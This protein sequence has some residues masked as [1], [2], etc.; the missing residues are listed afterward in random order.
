MPNIYRVDDIALR[1]APMIEQMAEMYAGDE[2]VHA[3]LRSLVVTREEWDDES[4]RG[5]HFWFDVSGP[6]VAEDDF[7]VDAHAFDV[8]G[9]T[10]ESRRGSISRVAEIS[11]RVMMVPPCERRSTELR[12]RGW[13]CRPRFLLGGTKPI[14]W[15]SRL[16]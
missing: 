6:P 12:N 5:G 14:P 7:L 13:F 10:I 11:S 3:Q 8:D 15:I 4:R 16:M 9:A 2:A 1:Y